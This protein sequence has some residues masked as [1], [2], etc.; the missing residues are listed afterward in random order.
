MCSPTVRGPTTTNGAATTTNTSITMYRNSA[1]N[2]CRTGWRNGVWSCASTTE[3][4]NVDIAD[5][6]A[7]S[8]IKKPSDTTSPRAWAVMSRMVGSM[9]SLTTLGEKKLWAVEIT[10]LL[11]GGQRVRAEQRRYVGQGCPAFPTTAA[12]GITPTKSPP[13]RTPRRL[14]RPSFST[15]VLRLIRHMWWRDGFGTWSLIPVQHYR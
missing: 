9:I 8:E 13:A 7:H 6:P 15:S 4:T 11:D 12:A 1:K 2:R 10:R 5:D 3:S 14:S